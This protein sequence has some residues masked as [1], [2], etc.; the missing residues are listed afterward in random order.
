MGEEKTILPFVQQINWRSLKD[1][2]EELCPFR[3]HL[4]LQE[5]ILLIFFIFLEASYLLREKINN[6]NFTDWAQAKEW[7]QS[8]E[9]VELKSF[10]KENWLKWQ[11]ITSWKLITSQSL[12]LYELVYICC[13]CGQILAYIKP[14]AR[15]IQ[16]ILTSQPLKALFIY[17]SC[18]I[19]MIRKTY[20][21]KMNFTK[22]LVVSDVIHCSF[23][24]QV[25]SFIY[26][27]HIYTKKIIFDSV[28]N[29]ALR[30]CEWNKIKLRFYKNSGIS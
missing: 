25:Y 3:C 28:N 11:F 22:K 5:M 17:N 12:E 4:A 10:H 26:S 6:H 15:K 19:K 27:S 18:L 8:K 14:N 23:K 24:L 20:H 16:I 13:I 7:M 9:W 30:S 21:N 1:T 29:W 2:N